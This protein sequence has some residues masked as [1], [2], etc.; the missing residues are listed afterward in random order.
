MIETN[1]T[2]FGFQSVSPEEK[3]RRVADV[4]HNVAENY[5][6]MNDLMSLGVHRL[7]KRHTVHISQVRPGTHIL[8]LA[9]GTGDMSAL[10]HDRVGRQG[11]VTVADVNESMLREGRSRLIDR[12]FVE[13]V[14][15][16]QTNA[17]SLPFRDN[18]FDCICIAF[19]LR[20]VTDKVKALSS[21]RE[22]LKFGGSV[23]I[24]E[25]SRVAIPVLR[26]LY[27]RYSFELIPKLGKLIAGDMDSYQYLVESIRRHPDQ[28]TL[29]IMMETAGFHSVSYYN[30]TAGVVAI[31]KG[32]K[33]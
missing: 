29:K 6:L 25:F 10:F 4:F 15:Y 24:L 8:D 9:G 1:H 11:S 13:G 32:Y 31:H 22:K 3:T 20:N 14:N 5:D 30:L 19:G 21:M 16:V 26:K 28:E 2:D 7:W 33:L 12:G 18:Y 23:V 27:D 17:E